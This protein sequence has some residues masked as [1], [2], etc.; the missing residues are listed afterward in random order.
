MSDCLLGVHDG[1]KVAMPGDRLVSGA[2][3]SPRR[4]GQSTISQF[5][6]VDADDRVANDNSQQSFVGRLKTNWRL[7]VGVH[8][9]SSATGD[10]V[11]GR[12]VGFLHG[13]SG[14][15][16][17]ALKIGPTAELEYMAHNPAGGWVRV[18]P[19]ELLSTSRRSS[20]VEHRMPLIHQLRWSFLKHV[21]TAGWT[22]SP[23][24]VVG[25]SPTSAA[26]A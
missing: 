25:S 2:G 15:Y 12:R 4:R 23:L 16:F 22:T 3:V 21:P 10:H 9:P 20:M 24:G 13:V 18:P 14:H 19:A 6:L 1:L 17:V 7:P 8:R 11:S 5:T 26:F